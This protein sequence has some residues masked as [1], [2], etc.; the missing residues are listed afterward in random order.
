[1]KRNDVGE[2]KE[3]RGSKDLNANKKEKREGKNRK[4]SDKN[5][6]DG[7]VTFGRAF[8]EMNFKNPSEDESIQWTSSRINSKGTSA[9]QIR[10]K[11]A[12]KRVICKYKCKLPYHKVFQIKEE[13]SV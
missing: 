9:S 13:G 10:S 7:N 6:G 8:S 1:M 12:F 4:N 3:S 11:C 2:R 5:I